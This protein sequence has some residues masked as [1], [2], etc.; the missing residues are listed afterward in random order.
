MSS[1]VATVRASMAVNFSCLHRL[2]TQY[3]GFLQAIR[4]VS[5]QGR[6]KI[7][8]VDDYSQKLLG[9]VLKQFDILEE[10][11]TRTQSHSLDPC[12]GPPDALHVVI[13]SISNY[14][15]PQQFEAVYILMP[16]TQNV[17]R[18]I[19]DFSNDHQQYLCAHL[20]FIEG[21]SVWRLGHC[22]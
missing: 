15:E 10:N 6:W 11:V 19:K 5:P 20:F 22:R 4:S 3:P 13:E 1:L 21:A 14:R 18:I 17:E 7:L 9:S 16:T 12:P 8:V 2:T